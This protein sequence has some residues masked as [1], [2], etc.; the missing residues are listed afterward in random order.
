[1]YDVCI[2]GG[3]P[4]GVTAA[5]YCARYRL[6]TLLITQDF[7]GWVK[8]AHRIEN[9][10]SHTSIVG[11][12][13]AK[14]YEEH[15]RSNELD[16]KK[17]ICTGLSKDDS[18]FNVTTN[19]GS[20]PSRYVIYAL[21]TKK[22]MLDIPG[23]KSLMGKGVCLCATCDA[24]FFRNKRVAVLGGNDS[25]ATSAL[26]ISEYAQ[27]VY[28]CEIMPKLPAEPVWQKKMAESGRIEIMLGDSAA[29]ILG[30]RKVTGIRMRSGKTI[31]V[32]GVFIEV[33][34]DPDS[35]LAKSA[36]ADVD[37]WGHVRVDRSQMSSVDRLYAA[38][39]VTD[40]SNYMRQ[41]VAAQAEGAVAAQAIYRRILKGE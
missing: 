25:G 41:I 28:V 11:R 27:Q 35:G 7:G 38:G 33:G 13:L 36:G 31:E 5:I 40:G 3:G 32:D 34:S 1:M 12:D 8:K 15:V 14:L 2:L 26:L 22:R 4:A 18:G 19:Q 17:D 24:P 37:R 16:I 39:D 30:D 6:K 21:G 29:E 10:P 20:F 23:E 9:C